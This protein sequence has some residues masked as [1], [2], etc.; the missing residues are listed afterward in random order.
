MHRTAALLGFVLAAAPA[1][2]AASE[3][4]VEP[5]AD[6]VYT[7]RAKFYANLFIVTPEGVIATDPINPSVAR[8]YRLAIRQVT[9]QPVR[10]VIY[11]HDHSDHISGGGVF[12]DT[13]V[14]V[15]HENAVARIRARHNPDI[16][17]PDITFRDEYTLTLGGKVV[18]LLY[19]GE[20]HSAS[21]IGIF[22]PAEKIL[23]L[24][25]MVYPGSV[26]FRDLPG[27]DIRGLLQTLPRLRA[28]DFET[29]LYGHGPPGTKDWVDKYIAYFDDLLAAL[30]K[31]MDGADAFRA[32][33]AGAPLDARKALDLYVDG[34]TTRAVEALRP[35]YGRWGGYDEWARMNAKAFLFYLMMDA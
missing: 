21:N 22:L 1:G 18:R 2:T 31:A 28:L 13:A 5:L 8:L 24:V 15:A 12:R 25:D 4:A 3:F 23:M 34:V 32:G 17:P 14:F 33:D 9:Q 10:Y 27:T 7:F 26:P 16:V 30:G 19:F 29:L 20:N 6:G 35:R 11:S